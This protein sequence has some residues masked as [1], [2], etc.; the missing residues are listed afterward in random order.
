MNILLTTMKVFLVLNRVDMVFTHR[1]QIYG[2]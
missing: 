2:V 1:G